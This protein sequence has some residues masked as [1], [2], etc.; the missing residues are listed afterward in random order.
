MT[1]ALLP[2][3]GIQIRQGAEGVGGLVQEVAEVL[4]IEMESQGG[5]R[6]TYNAQN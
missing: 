1:I 6:G 4:G 3:R 5:T 2:Y